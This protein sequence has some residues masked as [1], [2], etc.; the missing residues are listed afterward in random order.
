MRMRT[1]ILGV[2]GFAALLVLA[3][4]ARAADGKTI[5]RTPD[6]HPDLSGTYDVATLTPLDAPG[7]V[8]RQGV[9]HA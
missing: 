3:P 4:A 7:D 6:G 9:H 2:A 1:R 5:A 8:R